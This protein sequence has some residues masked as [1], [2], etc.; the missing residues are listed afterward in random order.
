MYFLLVILHA[1]ADLTSNTVVQKV[2][3][4][5]LFR[6]DFNAFVPKSLSI[7]NETTTDDGVG[8]YKLPPTVELRGRRRRCYTL[9]SPEG[10]DLAE[11]CSHRC[12]Q[13]LQSASL[14]THFFFIP[15]LLGR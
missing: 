10:A 9:A 6:V 8:N 11:I 1:F 7:L 12:L 14:K 3:V 15:W 5:S 4:A 2:I 13:C